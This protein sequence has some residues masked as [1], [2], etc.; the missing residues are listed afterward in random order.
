MRVRW[1]SIIN[2]PFG[3]HFSRRQMADVLEEALC[4]VQ[5]DIDRPSPPD[6]DGRCKSRVLTAKPKVKRF[7]CCV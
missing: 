6:G 3:V 4:V 7:W 2:G 5:N 1:R